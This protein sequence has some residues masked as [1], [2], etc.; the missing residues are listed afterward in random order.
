VAFDVVTS[1]NAR[2]ARRRANIRIYTHGRARGRRLLTGAVRDADRSYRVSRASNV[3]VEAGAAIRPDGFDLANYWEESSSRFREQ[4]PQIQ[5]RYLADPGVLRW[6]R[7]K[8]WRVVEQ[9]GEGERLRLRLRFDSEEEVV[10]VALAHGAAIELIEPAAL[11]EVV[12]KAT[13]GTVER[14]AP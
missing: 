14:Y 8:G 5:A 12:R 13:A 2:T 1:G 9:G 3:V 7:Y 6:I 4:L 11:R 10:Q